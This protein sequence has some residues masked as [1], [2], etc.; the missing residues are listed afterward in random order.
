MA[1]IT[2]YIP[3]PKAAYEVDNQR[4]IITSIDTLKANLILAFNKT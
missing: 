1:K 4:Q 2:V 3:E